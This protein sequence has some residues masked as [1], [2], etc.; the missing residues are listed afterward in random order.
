M[1]SSVGKIGTNERTLKVAVIG[2]LCAL[3]Y[4]AVAIFRIP[5]IP[6]MPFLR[7]DPKDVIITF[8]GLSL[9]PVSAA[10]MTVIVSF[11]E[12]VT[13]SESGIIGFVMNVLSTASFACTASLIYK[14]RHN[15][16]G[17]IAGLCSGW[18][19]MLVVMLLWNWLITPLYMSMTREAVEKL[20]IPSILPFNFVKGGFNTA[21]IMLIYKPASNVLKHTGLSLGSAD[22][23]GGAEN[24]GRSMRLMSLWVALPIAVVC[25]AVLILVRLI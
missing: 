21:L 15:F 12:M 9:G 13:V 6:S 3:A 11:I 23:V 2:V 14:K 7:Y 8:A 18:A 20:L 22:T 24:S 16:R 25:A 5:L 10:V 19:F 4:V 17:A 1:K